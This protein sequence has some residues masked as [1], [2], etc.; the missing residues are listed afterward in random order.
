MRISNTDDIAYYSKDD[1]NNWIKMSSA[2][3]KGSGK[4]A[5]TKYNG[6]YRFI[7]SISGSI[8]YSDN[9]GQSW[10]YSSGVIGTNIGIFVKE[11]NPN[12]VYYYSRGDTNGNTYFGVSKDGG[13]AL[14]IILFA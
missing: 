1:G 11:S 8:V 4:G 13:K 7:H 5:I 14:H 6:N 3:G 2:G 9:Y 12:Y 10:S